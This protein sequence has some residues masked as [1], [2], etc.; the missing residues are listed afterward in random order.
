MKSF[1]LLFFAFC[2]IILNACKK[3]Q[4]EEPGLSKEDCQV[5]AINKQ[6][7]PACVLTYDEENRVKT[8][9]KGDERR[10]YKYVANTVTVDRWHS[11]SLFGWQSIYTLNGTGLPVNEKRQYYSNNNWTNLAYEYEGNKI[12][13]ITTTQSS[14]VAPVY[15]TFTWNNDNVESITEYGETRYYDYYTDQPADFDYFEFERIFF[16]Q[17]PRFIV[18][19]NRVKSKTTYGVSEEYSYTTDA[20]GRVKA[21]TYKYGPATETW[22]VLMRCE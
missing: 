20:S 5:Q 1:Y 3:S 21:V 4:D 8:V 12:Q 19:R 22:E 16:D 7:T 14:G 6:T 11:G 17:G 18:N 15:A 2:I 10:E 13:K 9:T